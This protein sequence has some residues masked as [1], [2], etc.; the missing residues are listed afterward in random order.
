MGIK[1]CR[2]N[3]LSFSPTQLLSRH[4]PPTKKWKTRKNKVLAP[5]LNSILAKIKK[6]KFMWK[7]KL[8]LVWN[9]GLYL[10]TRN[11]VT[12]TQNIFTW[13][14]YFIEFG[15]E[16]FCWLWGY[17]WKFDYK[18]K[19]MYHI[20]YV[21]SLFYRISHDSW[22]LSHGV[23]FYEFVAE[24]VRNPYGVKKS[25]F[26]IF[27]LKVT[28]GQIRSYEVIWGHLRPFSSLI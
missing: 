2:K 28:R 25:F 22:V 23:M 14:S 13:L 18:I 7:S 24:V 4:H 19:E 12:P 9:F 1:M 6:K 11:W 17:Q 5:F 27:D 26:S 20:K 10:I 8:C 21:P 3:S 16:I 15:T